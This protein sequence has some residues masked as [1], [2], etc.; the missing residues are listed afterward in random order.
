MAFNRRFQYFDL[1]RHY[2]F[3]HRRVLYHLSLLVKMA[4]PLQ[5]LIAS[6]LAKPDLVQ[7]KISAL[8]IIWKI[9][10]LFKKTNYELLTIIDMEAVLLLQEANF[11]SLDPICDKAPLPRERS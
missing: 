9:V 6:V 10:A 8:V 3:F 5:V 7:R 11:S 4:A 2:H 1:L